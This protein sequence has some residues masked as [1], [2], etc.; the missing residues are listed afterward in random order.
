MVGG[1]IRSHA[2]KKHKKQKG[3]AAGLMLDIQSG[4]RRASVKYSR[5]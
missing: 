3:K 1:N 5:K 4:E 2:G